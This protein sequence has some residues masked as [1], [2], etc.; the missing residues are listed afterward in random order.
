MQ[1]HFREDDIERTIT[2]NDGLRT[3]TVARDRIAL[4]NIIIYPDNSQ[5]S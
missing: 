5:L 4:K 2:Y 3:V 1:H